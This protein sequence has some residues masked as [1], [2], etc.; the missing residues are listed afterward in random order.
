M[1]TT[2]IDEP[3]EATYL[4]YEELRPGG[5]PDA[6]RRLYWPL[7]GEFPLNIFVMKQQRAPHDLEPL[8]QPD[9]N[10]NSN[11]GTW[12]EIASQP[13]TKRKVS[14]I[15]ARVPELDQW[16][17]HWRD[18]HSEHACPESGAEYITE[19]D[20]D[21]ALRDREA[22][23]DAKVLIRCCGEERPFGKGHRLITV[24][25]LEG[26]GFVTVKDYVCRQGRITILWARIIG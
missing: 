17:P 1:D 18:W 22:D 20:L 15:T 26:S 4:S 12:H 24:V 21:D 16:G 19:A 6:M 23:A 5:V 13:C 3:G 2:R 7:E 10:G 8:F 14:S 11:S 9:G 25:P